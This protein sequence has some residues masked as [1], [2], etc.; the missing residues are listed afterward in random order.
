MAMRRFAELDDC[1]GFVDEVDVAEGIDV[2]EMTLS[3]MMMETR[4]SSVIGS[5]TLSRGYRGTL[6]GRGHGSGRRETEWVNGEGTVRMEEPA[7]TGKCRRSFG[8]SH[9][10]WTGMPSQRKSLNLE[11]MESALSHQ[12]EAAGLRD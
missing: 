8:T 4:T 6:D 3:R 7:S 11:V 1:E 2:S 9:S 12:V 5:T 10:G